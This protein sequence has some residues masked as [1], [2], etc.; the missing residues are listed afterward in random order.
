MS[1]HV[2][3]TFKKKTNVFAHSDLI[4]IF[5]EA[6]EYFSLDSQVEESRTI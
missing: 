4:G 5:Q 1:K 6:K 3:I 2:D